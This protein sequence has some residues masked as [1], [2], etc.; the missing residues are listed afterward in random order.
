M[1]GNALMNGNIQGDK[2]IWFVGTIFLLVGLALYL[3]LPTFI[4]KTPGPNDIITD[5][6]ITGYVD[7]DEG[8]ATPLFEY[9]A[10]DN[11]PHS[12]RGYIWSNT[13]S[14]EVGDRIRVFYS[15][16]LPSEGFI[17][18]DKNAAIMTI[19]T[20]VLGAYFALLG[21][22]I[23]LLKLRGM[24]NIRIEVF[25]GAIGSLSFGIPATLVL[26]GLYYLYQ[27]RPNFI[28]EAS[29]TEFP[30][31]FLLLGAVFTILGII[32]L[33]ATWYLI[34]NYQKTGSNVISKHYGPT[35]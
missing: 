8:N 18:D 20:R 21:F 12:S 10:N 27:N 28:F 9:T 19:I 11:Q 31:D 32:D 33:V 7:D 2:K 23:L 17:L 35:T 5:G 6:T 26:P 4:I 1:D 25:S 24:K 13:R 29:L 15:P 14:Y 22:V 16:T 34:R 3:L 30:R